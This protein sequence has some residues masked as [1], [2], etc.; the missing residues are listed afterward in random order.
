MNEFWRHQGTAKNPKKLLHA[1]LYVRKEQVWVITS[2][3][4]LIQKGNYLIRK[5]TDLI[6][7][8][9]FIMYLFIFIIKVF[10]METE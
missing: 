7:Q 10:V 8:V 3:F 9:L 2:S 1:A 6:F 5:E 4:H